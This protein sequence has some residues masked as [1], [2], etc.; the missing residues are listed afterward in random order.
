MP[1][2]AYGRN[3]SHWC[4][5][6]SP[7]RN[8]TAEGGR[9]R[10]NAAPIPRESAYVVPGELSTEAITEALLT[11]SPT[12]RRSI[13]RQRFTVLDTVDGRVRQAGACLTRADV[14]S[15]STVRW[16]TL[17]GSDRFAIRTTRPVG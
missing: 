7:E 17:A 15:A 4:I 14:D 10:M 3:C 12:R 16:Q 13:A 1:P 9:T 5:G 8:L 2:T 11:L 6:S